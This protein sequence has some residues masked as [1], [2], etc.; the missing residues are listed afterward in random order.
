MKVVFALVPFF[1]ILNSYAV[2]I[3]F[4]KY[5]DSTR[6]KIL[7]D[8]LKFL[9]QYSFNQE[10]ETKTLKLL[11]IPSMSSLELEEWLDL[12]VS[13]VLGEEDQT[14]MG[15]LRKAITYPQNGEP[16]FKKQ[17]VLV[18]EKKPSEQP[19]EE[20]N[21]ESKPIATA[22]EEEKKEPRM[23]TVMSNFGFSIYYH[24]KING[25]I[26]V[27]NF[28]E[29]EGEVRPVYVSSPR[30]GIIRVGEGLFMSQKGFGDVDSFVNRVYR[31][32]TLFHEARHSDGNGESL[33]FGHFI[34]PISHPYAGSHACD[35]NN[36]GPYSVGS[37]VLFEMMKNCQTCT[38]REIT[39]LKSVFLDRRS[40]ILPANI[41]EIL[42]KAYNENEKLAPVYNDWNP[43]P[44]VISIF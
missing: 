17:K 8:D 4:S 25:R 27:L 44:E 38:K 26:M 41:N 23:T 32:V 2:N 34:C 43:S 12:R 1:L 9:A 18:F 42:I 33:G 14:Q 30:V 3:K 19:R 40:R 35:G 20:S 6:K 21:P 28:E 10:A 29:S 13:Y 22:P 36:N 5:V 39:I 7:Q 24:G 11:D 15:A 37:S 31:V 16:A